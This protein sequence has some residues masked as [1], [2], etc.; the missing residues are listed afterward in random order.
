M[1]FEKY[2]F[3]PPTVSLVQGEI[4]VPQELHSVLLLLLKHPK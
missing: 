1:G 2:M 4:Q 3:F